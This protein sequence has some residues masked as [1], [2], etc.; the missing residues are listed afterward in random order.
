MPVQLDSVDVI[1]VKQCFFS[2]VSF[3]VVRPAQRNCVKADMNHLFPVH[4]HADPVNMVNLGPAVADRT[5]AVLQ[6]QI[7]V[8]ADVIRL[9]QEA[10]LGGNAPVKAEGN[11]ICNELPSSRHVA[12]REGEP[13]PQGAGAEVPLE[14]K[15]QFLRLM[16]GPQGDIPNDCEDLPA[17]VG[18][19]GTP[20]IKPDFNPPGSLLSEEPAEE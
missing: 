5:A 1:L 15:P 7:Q 14:I 16:A 19:D 12:I 17:L 6:A 18:R 13:L 8:F 4:S 10:V 20:I 3:L 11:Q 9:R 2:A